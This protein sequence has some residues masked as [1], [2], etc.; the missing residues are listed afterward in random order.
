MQFYFSKFHFL[1]L[2]YYQTQQPMA[3]AF[4]LRISPLQPP[5][6]HNGLKMESIS[7]ITFKIG[8]MKSP[9]FFSF[10]EMLKWFQREFNQWIFNNYQF[11]SNSAF[12]LFCNW[13]Y[14]YNELIKIFFISFQQFFFCL[15]HDMFSNILSIDILKLLMSISLFFWFS[16]WRPWCICRCRR[17]ITFWWIIFNIWNIYVCDWT[18]WVS[19]FSYWMILF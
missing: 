7:D 9:M 18:C 4:H 6:L 2:H 11:I 16:W 8:K 1:I 13:S 12:V 19:W 5:E 15:V 10:N 3:F 17:R 14:I